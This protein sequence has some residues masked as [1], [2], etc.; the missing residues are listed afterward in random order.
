[1][2]EA[3][4]GWF[5]FAATL[6]ADQTILYVGAPQEPGLEAL[7]AAARSVTVSDSA[8]LVHVEQSAYDAVTSIGGWEW[9]ESKAIKTLCRVAR[10]KVFV[11]VPNAVLFDRHQNEAQRAIR[12]RAFYERLASY[13]S[14]TVYKGTASGDEVLPVR[15]IGLY[16]MLHDFLNNEISHYPTCVFERL[17]PG[18]ARSFPSTAALVQLKA[19]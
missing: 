15:H 11:A 16:L 4:E 12:L 13:G 18:R 17:L 19:K 8:G 6:L 9:G 14:L 3:R 2:N 5:R 10:D 1:M 7:T